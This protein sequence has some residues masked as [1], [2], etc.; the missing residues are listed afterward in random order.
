MIQ[1][2]TTKMLSG[3][4]G[5]DIP[6]VSYE[7]II[8]LLEQK[9]IYFFCQI[10]EKTF[11]IKDLKNL[12]KDDLFNSFYSKK[13]KKKYQNNRYKMFHLMEIDPEVNF[14]DVEQYV[15]AN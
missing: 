10:K 6:V 15:Q 7:N 13:S 1:Y 5:N 12:I 9:I 11:Q 3:K 14:D 2:I 4:V 8:R